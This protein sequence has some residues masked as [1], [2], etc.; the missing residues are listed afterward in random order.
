MKQ[1][2]LGG[3]RCRCASLDALRMGD[4][5]DVND[6]LRVGDAWDVNDALRVG[7]AWDV[8]DVL[9]VG[10]AWALLMMGT[11]CWC[12]PGSPM[13][14][15]QTRLSEPGP[16]NPHVNPL[17]GAWARLPTYGTAGLR[18]DKRVS[19][20]DSGFPCVSESSRCRRARP[21]PARTAPQNG[22]HR[23]NLSASRSDEPRLLRRRAEARGDEFLVFVG[24]EVADP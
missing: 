19:A 6:A 10:D 13:L 12:A 3:S 20:P 21:P 18:A 11:H 24:C 9:R 15:T 4:A 5:R 8:N 1:A 7:D 16:P 23:G 22:S 17:I 2:V 14:R